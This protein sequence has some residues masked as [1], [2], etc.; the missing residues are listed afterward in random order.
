MSDDILEELGYLFDWSPPA[1]QL[2]IGHEKYNRPEDEYVRQAAFYDMRLAPNLVCKR[3]VYVENLYR[4]LCQI[5]DTKIQE[6][7]D[8]GVTFEPSTAYGFVDKGHREGAMRRR[9]NLIKSKQS[10]V[11]YYTTV[12]S[13]SCLPVA[14]SLALHPQTWNTVITWDA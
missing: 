13:D 11:A 10:L 6:A 2:P 1:L 3:L 4:Q 9:S 14:S 12:T 7:H 8:R 5:V